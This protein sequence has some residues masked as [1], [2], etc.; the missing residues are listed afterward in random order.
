MDK[1]IE[2]SIAKLS[3]QLSE[4]DSKIDKKLDCLNAQIEKKFETF[5]AEIEK[6]CEY[7]I[8]EKFKSVND[9]IDQ[10]FQ[11]VR[12]EITKSSTKNFVKRFHSA[13]EGLLNFHNGIF[14]PD[15]LEQFPAANNDKFFAIFRGKLDTLSAFQLAEYSLQFLADSLD[16]VNPRLATLLL[17]DRI[18]LDQAFVIG[19][20]KKHLLLRF[21]SSASAQKFRDTVQDYN[22]QLDAGKRPP[23]RFSRL[24][25]GI[26]AIDRSLSIGNAVLYSA[27]KAGLISS[28]LI[29]PKLSAESGT[30]TSS[31]RVRFNG[32]V[33]W[34]SLSWSTQSPEVARDD[35]LKI[36][37][38]PEASNL[39]LFEKGIQEVI[40]RY[41]DNPTPTP[42]LQR[43]RVPPP[44]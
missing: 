23:L 3:S 40:E 38:N 4:L 21:A 17:I 8:N 25:T 24:R 32:D 18:L 20:K 34:D 22:K 19:K 28:F 31:S 5:A 37:T 13:T 27:K 29:S 36:I 39:K 6:F 30:L 2:K 9:S 35:L 12:D 16:S 44:S 26:E 42:R 43:K 1:Q 33:G 15:I 7:T 41:S 14:M 10:S 11:E